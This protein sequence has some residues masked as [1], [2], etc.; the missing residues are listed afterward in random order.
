MSEM[1]GKW[2]ILKNDEIIAE[3]LDA[4]KILTLA[5]KYNEKDILITKIPSAKYCFY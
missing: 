5:E 1:S 3:D 4:K 2:V